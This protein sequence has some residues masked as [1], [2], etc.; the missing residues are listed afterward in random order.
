MTP[1]AGQWQSSLPGVSEFW[2]EKAGTQI[3]IREENLM[4]GLVPIDEQGTEKL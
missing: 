3:E 2:Q 1:F 4:K